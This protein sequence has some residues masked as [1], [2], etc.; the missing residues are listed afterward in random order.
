ME[1]RGQ[2]RAQHGVHRSAARGSQTQQRG[3]DAIVDG[4][5]AAVGTVAT[6]SRWGPIQ[7]AAKWLRQG[8]IRG[9]DAERLARDAISEDPAR[10]NAAIDYLESKGMA[11]NRALRFVETYG[12]ALAGRVGGA[13][14]GEEQGLPTAGAP[15]VR[16]AN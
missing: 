15:Y 2:P 11:R 8:G 10:I 1:D 7:L 6:G 13:A 3:Q 4:F 14:Q 16:P 12:A 5:A 9:V